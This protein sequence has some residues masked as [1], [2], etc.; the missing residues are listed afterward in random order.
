MFVY[1]IDLTSMASAIRRLSTIGGSVS[2]FAAMA[3]GELLSTTNATLEK[4]EADHQ[5]RMAVI[6]SNINAML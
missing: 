2:N 3:I 1:K 5:P 6:Q 4:C